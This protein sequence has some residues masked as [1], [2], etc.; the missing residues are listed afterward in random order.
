[1]SGNH[2]ERIRFFLFKAP[3]TPLDL[4][5]PWL[6]QHNPQIDWGEV[7]LLVGTHGAM[8][9]VY[10]QLLLMSWR[11]E[12]LRPPD[13]LAV[14]T[15]Y[16]DL[17]QVFIKDLALSLPPHRPY[18]CGI[19]LLPG[20]PLPTSHLYSLFKS[21]REAMERCITDSLAAGIIRSCASPLS[22]G[23]FFVEKKDKT[24]L[25]CIDFCGLN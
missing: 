13:L 5:Y 23:A 15:E 2:V 8:S 4:G 25:P 11:P 18:D 10:S 9:L 21:E 12:M 24:L 20:A 17:S 1:M 22:A 19:D 14:S 16:H 3:N 6:H 7:G